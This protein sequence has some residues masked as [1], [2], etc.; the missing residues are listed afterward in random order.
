M[1]ILG[2]RFVNSCFMFK[3][4][5]SFNGRRRRTELALSYVIY[6]VAALTFSFSARLIPAHLSPIFLLL[7]IG[8]Y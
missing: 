1:K 3:T 7:L 5:F 8:L 2:N 4:P 6:V